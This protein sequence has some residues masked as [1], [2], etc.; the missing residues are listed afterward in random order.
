MDSPIFKKIEL[1]G[2]SENSI[3]EAINN[4]LLKASKTVRKMRWLEVVEIRGGIKDDRV[5]QWQVTVKIGF[6]LEDE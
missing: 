3:E 1:T 2:T 5:A 4:A 6:K